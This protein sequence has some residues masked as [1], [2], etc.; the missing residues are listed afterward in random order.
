[1]RTNIRCSVRSSGAHP[2][3]A[4]RI[5]RICAADRFGFSFLNADASSNTSPGVRGCDCLGLGTSASNPPRRHSAI[6][7]SSV[8]RVNRTTRP[9]GSVCA[10]AAIARTIAP[11]SRR[12]RLGSAACLISMYRS[13][14][15]SRARS[16]L[17]CFSSS[18]FDI[19][20]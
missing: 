15:I 20:L 13:N 1:M 14:P 19:R 2:S 18:T 3:C 8:Q 17:A 12:D 10:W 4:A 7:R 16:N 6:H 5:R 9:N 11:R